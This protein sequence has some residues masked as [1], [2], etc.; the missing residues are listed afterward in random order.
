MTPQIK[1]EISQLLRRDINPYHAQ[2]IDPLLQAIERDFWT[3]YPQDTSW[4]QEHLALDL[5]LFTLQRIGEQIK[6][7][8]DI[9][10]IF[11]HHEQAH[12]KTSQ[13]EERRKITLEF[14]KI[15]GA[16]SKQ[17]A[18]DKKAFDRW[19]GF[20]AVADRCREN[21]SH[22][23]SQTYFLLLR[24]PALFPF[25]K[26]SDLSPLEKIL[27]EHLGPYI[28][29]PYHGHYKV[30]EAFLEVLAHFLKLYGTY[31][32][33]LPSLMALQKN[34]MALAKDSQHV[35]IQSHAYHIIALCFPDLF[36][37]KATR[38]LSRHKDGDD[39]FLRKRIIDLLDTLPHIPES[40]RL[41]LLKEASQDPSIHVRQGVCENLKNLDRDAQMDL[42]EVLLFKESKTQV[43]AKALYCAQHIFTGEDKH[44]IF[45]DLLRRVFATQ[46]D[47]F[48]LRVGLRTLCELAQTKD[49][50]TKSN[51]SNALTLV[52]ALK[53]CTT[54][55]NIKRWASQTTELLLCLQDPVLKNLKENLEMSLAPLKT[56]HIFK[57]PKAW[58][59]GLDLKD[60]AR[61]LA[62]ISVN[63]FDYQV[64]S[65]LGRFYIQ[66]GIE[67][68]FRFWRF[69]HEM[70]LPRTEK[71]Q[72][73]KHTIGRIWRT[74][75]II[76]SNVLYEVSQTQ[77]PGEPVYIPQEAGWRPYL[78]LPDLC[79]S[80][81]ILGKPIYVHT[82]DGIT[83]IHAKGFIL[84]R[85]YARIKL[86]WNFAHFASLRHWREDSSVEPN[87]Y[88]H[89]LSKLG[90]NLNFIPHPQHGNKE[91]ASITRFFPMMGFAPLQDLSSFFEQVFYSPY[92]NTFSH[93]LIFIGI[94]SAIFIGEKLY[95]FHQ[96]KRI[97]SKIPL[98]FG[99]SGSRGKSSTARLKGALLNSIGYKVFVKT[100]GSE[101]K[102]LL[103]GRLQIMK[104][105]LLFRPF[106]KTTIWEQYK[107]TKLAQ[108][109][110][111]DAF[112]WECMALQP[113]Y[114][115][116][117]K[118]WMKDSMSS[119]TNTYPDHE[120]I[121]G[122][123]GIDVA[124]S[125]TYFTPNASTLLT[126]EEPMLPVLRQT[127]LENGS[128]LLQADWLD[129]GLI[130]P[131]IL[132]RFGYFEHPANLALTLLFAKELGV[133]SDY[134]MKEIADNIMPD[135]GALKCF[136]P[137]TNN[138]KQLEFINGMAANEE[139][140]C[141]SNWKRLGLDQ[142]T[143][144]SAP[145]IWITCIVNNRHDRVARSRVFAQMLISDMS[146][147]RYYLV[148]N[149]IKGFHLYIEDCLT[150]FLDQISW[151]H[152][153]DENLNH[154][155]KLA[156][157]FRLFT[158]L[159][160]LNQRLNV[161]LAAHPQAVS[162]IEELGDD[163][164][165]REIQRCHAQNLHGLE[166]YLSLKEHLLQGKIDTFYLTK[167]LTSL[168]MHKIILGQDDKFDED[169][170]FEQLLNETPPGMMN[171]ALGL[172]NIKGPG[173]QMVHHAQ[174]WEQCLF[175]G[176]KLL[177]N[178]AKLLS[179]GVRHLLAM[180]KFNQI[181]RAYLKTL[182]LWS[183]NPTLDSELAR[184][185]DR[186]EQEETRA[187]THSGQKKSFLSSMIS[188][189][190]D[191]TRIK[192]DKKISQHIYSDLLSHRVT[193]RRGAQTL[194]GLI[195]SYD[196]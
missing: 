54:M 131:E 47:P 37:E 100:T 194:E 98:V 102:I 189:A 3:H 18:Q 129:I 97:R 188:G 111:A 61:V 80:A 110:K 147:D 35:W 68:G 141:L 5:L 87:A 168:F 164:L 44:Q 190:I 145:H 49:W 114:I 116:Q 33:P 77:V 154:L 113:D 153:L 115:T 32:L 192:R 20:Q 29:G 13:E 34:L 120:D 122:P 196:D 169:A 144:E 10:H 85:L 78:P 64:N 106:G 112:V 8:E 101:S 150:E 163:P 127:A 133:P 148:G 71:R 57:V 15:L 103:S 39:L 31:N 1:E 195:Q 76:P 172:Q 27:F 130:P 178:N 79:L 156:H 158:S 67:K 183:Q 30:R 177:S 136:P 65:V 51:M 140:G 135:I 88:A 181:S 50:P 28:I 166:T 81:L 95:Y 40:A 96:I 134:A 11:A 41:V 174:I 4:N 186:L 52:L 126:S 180:P 143:P 74:Q 142:M 119:I 17:L 137:I 63:D 175:E 173:L 14:A 160:T 187:H 21:I 75:H 108:E 118:G 105:F 91:D 161:M 138:T 93:I 42:L 104:D 99:G 159:E 69:L 53:E 24:L 171:R 184:L 167:N 121:Q 16:S 155:K 43:Q 107:C 19:F 117:L 125:L 146:A 90:I 22:I 162:S 109:Y 45:L 139:F 191:M 128:R 9:K 73:F 92:I 46:T 179:Q 193:A 7:V 185:R 170:F 176:Q 26:A 23:E 165:A 182:P 6:Q 12:A 124:K 70:R 56:G 86:G 38:H 36:I 151:S 152:N 132:D 60:V 25:L 72:H 82:P 84:S 66:K 48:V 55:P 59:Q 89:A 62:V 94:L 157:K 149:N 123:S 2:V 58:S 83:Q